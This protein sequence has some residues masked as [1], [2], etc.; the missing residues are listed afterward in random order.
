[1]DNEKYNGYTNHATWRVNLEILD[2]LDW[3]DYK[4][5]ITADIIQEMVEEIVFSNSVEKNCLAAAYARA[6]LEDV[7][8]QE[9]ADNINYD[10]SYGW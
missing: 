10:R 6:F 4:K 3:D 5:D 9:I 1:M 8:Y 7:N 2:G